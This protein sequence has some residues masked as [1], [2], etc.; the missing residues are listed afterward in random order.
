MKI[1]LD[2]AKVLDQLKLTGGWKRDRKSN[3]DRQ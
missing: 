3:G 1:E 2:I